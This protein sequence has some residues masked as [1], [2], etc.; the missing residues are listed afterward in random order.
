MVDGLEPQEFVSFGDHMGV[1]TYQRFRST[2]E[3]L[4]A[5]QLQTQGASQDLR[6]ASRERAPRRRR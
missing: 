1:Q 4:E 3:E 2:R 5:K 6:E